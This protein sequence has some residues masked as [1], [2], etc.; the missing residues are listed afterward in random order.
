MAKQISKQMMVASKDV[1]AS[2]ADMSA[3]MLKSVGITP[4]HFR[5]VAWNALLQN[6]Y[7]ATCSAASLKKALLACAESG[8]MPDGQQAA[9]VPFK[10]EAQVIKMVGGL[11][12]LARRAIPGI[13]FEYAVVY[14]GDTF[15]HEQGLQSKLRHVRDEDAG[16]GWDNIR[17][18]WAL[19]HIPGNP[20][21]EFVVMYKGEL[22]DAKGMAQTQQVWNKHPHE[23]ALKTVLKS[24]CKRLPTRSPALFDDS[25]PVVEEE[26]F[27]HEEAAGKAKELL[28]NAQPVIITERYN[29]AASA[30]KAE[31][32]A[33]RI[34]SVT[35]PP[36]EMQSVLDEPAPAGAAP[37]PDDEDMSDVGF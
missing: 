3:D 33:P 8:L 24:L 26:P 22:A 7:I 25:I 12:D 37:G 23:M 13:S 17:A 36:E 4:E 15:E 2:G 18:A 20:R 34:E 10:G 21:P 31:E 30:P 11:L 9:L 16:R 14:S 35:L 27:E 1:I 19:A 32:P 6:P 28:A 5:R 29:Q